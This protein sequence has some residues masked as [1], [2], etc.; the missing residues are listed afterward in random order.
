M[1]YKIVFAGPPGVGKSTA[2]TA[3]CGEPPIR[4][5]VAATDE[6]ALIKPTTTVGFDYGVIELSRGHVL[7]L[8]GTPGQARFDFM[9]SI[10]SRGALGM[11]ILVD[12]SVDNPVEQFGYYL[13]TFTAAAPDLTVVVGVTRYRFG[14]DSLDDYYKLL[15]ERKLFMPIVPAD[16]REKSDVTMLMDIL[17]TEIESRTLNSSDDISGAIPALSSPQVTTPERA[18]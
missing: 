4:T 11:I 12:H 14:E 9:W 15:E 1:E 6:V 3:V 2:I 7:R 17:L 13:D 5:D 8:Y 10:L 18:I 16:A